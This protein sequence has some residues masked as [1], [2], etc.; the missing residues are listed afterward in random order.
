MFEVS[1]YGGGF[2]VVI[3]CVVFDI[4]FGGG[5]MGGCFVVIGVVCFGYD[6][7]DGCVNGGVVVVVVFRYDDFVLIFCLF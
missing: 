3:S 7:F 5:G 6:R 4:D 2:G 1:G